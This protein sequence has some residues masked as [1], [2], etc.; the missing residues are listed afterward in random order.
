MSTQSVGLRFRVMVLTLALTAALLPSA[1]EAQFMSISHYADQYVSG[2]DLNA[3][4][5]A[6]DDSSGCEHSDYQLD[7][8]GGSPTSSWSNSASGLAAGGGSALEQDGDYWAESN[9]T[10]QCSCSVGYISG[11]GGSI[12]SP[13]LSQLYR[14]HYLRTAIGNP[15]TYTLQPD[16]QNKSCSHSTLTWPSSPSPEPTRMNDEG[17]YWSIFGNAV[18]CLSLCTADWALPAEGPSGTTGGPASCG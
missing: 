11:G 17:F 8:W 18:A 5:S 14:H 4:M 3:Y 7:V 10:F 9:L 13:A 16:S 2:P 6:I 12:S 15:S 1:A